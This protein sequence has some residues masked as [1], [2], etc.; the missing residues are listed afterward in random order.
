MTTDVY[1]IIRRYCR[2][3]SVQR[4]QF[5]VVAA[6][7]VA[8]LGALWPV[9]TRSCSLCPT[10]VWSVR[11]WRDRS[12]RPPSKTTCAR[13]PATLWSPKPVPWAALWTPRCWLW[14][15]CPAALENF[16]NY[17]ENKKTISLNAVVNSFWNSGGGGF[18]PYLIEKNNP[19][20]KALH[21]NCF[22]DV[23][24]KKKKKSIFFLIGV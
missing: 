19:P 5:V 2:R 11:R 3:R 15:S 7:P 20:I 18:E 4:R 12:C 9:K 14:S 21:P 10:I 24:S 16:W 8:V 22:S 23:L 6:V 1:L 17:G 13:S